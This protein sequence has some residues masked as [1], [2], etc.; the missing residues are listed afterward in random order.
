M[1]HML[2]SFFLDETSIL[3]NNISMYVLDHLVNF[4]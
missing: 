4:F 2:I 3:I 1:Q